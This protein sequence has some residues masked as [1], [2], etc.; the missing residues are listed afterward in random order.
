MS[1]Q[2]LI[3]FIEKVQNDPKWKEEADLILLKNRYALSRH[4]CDERLIWHVM[5]EI[6]TIFLDGDEYCT[7]NQNDAIELIRIVK[8]YLD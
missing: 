7:V 5:D 3:D 4:E 8:S 2:D 1:K 6:R